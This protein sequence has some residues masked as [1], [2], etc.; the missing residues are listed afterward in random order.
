V[1]EIQSAAELYTKL[2][3][4]L[5]VVKGDGSPF[6]EPYGCHAPPRNGREGLAFWPLHSWRGPGHSP[7]VI[8]WNPR[9][10]RRPTFEQFLRVY[11]FK[12]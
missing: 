3:L 1:R 8:E 5:N 4:F 12:P 6:R 9:G 2:A 7:L 11:R 10:K